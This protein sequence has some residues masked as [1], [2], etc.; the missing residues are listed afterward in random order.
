MTP[1]TTT[2]VVISADAPDEGEMQAVAVMTLRDYFAARVI[3][4]AITNASIPG[5]VEGNTQTTA[6]VDYMCNSS[7]IV[8]DAMLKARQA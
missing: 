1:Y 4:A 2:P 5:L 3:A 7:Y 6:M 8:A